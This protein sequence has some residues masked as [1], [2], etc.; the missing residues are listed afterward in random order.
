[1][2][3]L[4]LNVAVIC[5]IQLPQYIPCSKFAKYYVSR[6]QVGLNNVLMEKIAEDWFFLY[7]CKC[8]IECI[9]I[10]WQIQSTLIHNI[11]LSNLVLS[12]P[13]KH[14]VH[15]IVNYLNAHQCPKSKGIHVE[16]YYNYPCHLPTI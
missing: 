13:S 16:R 8:E 7:Y 15:C 1:M 5:I 14:K 4:V 9:H 2:L 11:V 10:E 3:S 12:D 6:V